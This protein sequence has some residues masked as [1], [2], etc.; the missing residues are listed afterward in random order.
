[1]VSFSKL[2]TL[3]DSCRATTCSRHHLEQEHILEQ[4]LVFFGGITPKGFDILKHNRLLEDAYDNQPEL[5]LLAKQK[6]E[7]RVFLVF[8]NSNSSYDPSRGYLPEQNKLPLQ[9]ID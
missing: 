3:S 8:D 9:L 5:K 4:F 1:M 7:T 2:I 6:W